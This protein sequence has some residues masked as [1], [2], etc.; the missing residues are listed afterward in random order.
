[1]QKSLFPHIPTNQFFGTRIAFFKSFVR[2]DLAMRAWFNLIQ[3]PNTELAK[4]K[5]ELTRDSILVIVRD[6]SKPVREQLTADEL[7]RYANQVFIDHIAR[8]GTNLAVTHKT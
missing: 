6:N 1:M 2:S 8:K 3:T 7:K 4:S 5:L